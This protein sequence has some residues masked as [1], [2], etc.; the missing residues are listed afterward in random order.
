LLFSIF[1][2][3]SIYASAANPRQLCA[4][5]ITTIRGL[6]PWS[7]VS[8]VPVPEQ[9]WENNDEIERRRRADSEFQIETT[10]AIFTGV[11]IC[12][13]PTIFTLSLSCVCD[14]IAVPVVGSFF[15]RF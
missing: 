9:R 14:R 7:K 4:G 11:D 2:N 8:T 5:R 1:Y 15:T 3:A 10:P 13:L 12:A 6:F